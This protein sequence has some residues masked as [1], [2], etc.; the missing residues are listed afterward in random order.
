[1]DG[2]ALAKDRLR[3]MLETLTG[4]CRI[5]EACTRLGISEPRFYQLREQM[6]TAALAGLEPRSA[7]RPRRP[8]S[9]GD[10]EIARLQ[11]QLNDRDLE[12]KLARTREEIA[13]VLPRATQPAPGKKTRRRDKSR[14]PP[15]R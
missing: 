9:A 5:G 14:R 7:G 1:L 4:R 6:L 3:I 10:G 11:Q 2:S 13:L 8:R 12:L 15:S